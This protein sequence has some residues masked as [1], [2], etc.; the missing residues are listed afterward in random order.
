MNEVRRTICSAKG[1]KGWASRI[2]GESKLAVWTLWCNDRAGRYT[3]DLLE[4]DLNSCSYR[5]GLGHRRSSVFGTDQ[6]H[7]EA[8]TAVNF[9]FAE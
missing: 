7:A 4:L 9:W 2:E 3:K 8:A 5:D 1:N 6:C